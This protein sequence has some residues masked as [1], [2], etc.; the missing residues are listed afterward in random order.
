MTRK[1]SR[2]RAPHARKRTSRLYWMMG[3]GFVLMACL[4]L[5]HFWGPQAAI[6]KAPADQGQAPAG[7][8]AAAP[9]PQ[10]P[11][12]P[13]KPLTVV[14][15]V[16]GEQ[17]TRAELAEE[18]LRR[19]GNDVLESIVNKHLIWQACQS[20]GLEITDKDVEDEIGRMAAKFGLSPGRWLALLQ[21]EREISPEQYRREI[22]WP[23]LALRELAAKE[24]EVT[25]QELQDAMEAEYGPR[26]KARA[27]TVSS[28]AK[29]EE[30]RAKAVASPAEFGE[31]AKNNSEDQSASVNGLIPPIRKHVGD[32]N[33]ERIAFGLKEGEISPIIQVANQFVILQCEKQLPEPYIAPHFR[34]DAENR[35][36][37]RVQDQKLR[38]TASTLFQRLQEAAKVVN[39]YNDAALRKEMPG[40]AATV[41]GQKISIQQLGEEC[42]IRNGK[43]VLDGE[44]H[45]RLLQQMLKKQS[46]AVTE[47]DIDREIARAAAA[48]GYLKTDGSPDVEKW[49]KDVTKEK[50][51]TVE[52]YVRDAVWPSIALKKLVNDRVEVTEEDIQKGFVSNY[53]PRVEVLAIVLNDHRQ[54]QKVW[55]M[56][57][58]NSTD[59]F[60][61]ELAQQYS[62]DAVSRENFGRVPPVRQFGGRPELEKEA[63]AMKPGDL[64]GIIASEDSYIILRC[65]GH[66]TPVVAN[67]DADVRKELVEDIREKKI[68]LAM[69]VEFDRLRESAQIENFLAG[70]FQSPNQPKASPQPSPRPTISALPAS[71]PRH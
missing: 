61:G 54:A 45:R 4:C 42:V 51:A 48:Y 32:E 66:T 22:V 24:I 69:S 53:G 28:Q 71:A 14:A 18:C 57:R 46:Q 29:A 21:E 34:Q 19:Y 63:F 59:Q 31:L 37:D 55:E 23:T 26:V 40:V 8:S 44:I 5:R 47:E 17:I 27:I 11:T 58:D 25:P 33:I 35:I 9:A 70:T 62:V 3:A 64:S 50:G 1:D 13:S 36:R 2:G 56:A 38:A 43:D 67:L 68:R 52:L 6:A 60:F 65:T 16:N 49:L 7:A 39:V 10:I 15:S 12:E 30:L 41:N 20:Q